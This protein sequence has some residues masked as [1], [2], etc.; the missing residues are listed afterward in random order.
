MSENVKAIG[1]MFGLVG[2]L[3]GTV[4]MDVAMM[5]IFVSVGERPDMFFAMVGEK[6]G[7]TA[8]LGL[9]IHNIIGASGGFVFSLIV[10]N[11]SALE[12]TSV[13]K[14]LKLGVA[15]GVITIPLGCVPMAIWLGEPVMNVVAF[16]IV[17]HLVWGTVLGWIVA[18]GLLRFTT[19]S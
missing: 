10:L 16:S 5:I 12:L 14:G 19:R 13:G 7:G 11:I 1:V 6:V 18:S 2:G 3:V 17:P 8:V 9:A 4:L 15:A